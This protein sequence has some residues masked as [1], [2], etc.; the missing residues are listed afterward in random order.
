MLEAK[1][2]VGDVILHRE[3]PKHSYQNTYKQTE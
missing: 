1:L 3:N 2:F